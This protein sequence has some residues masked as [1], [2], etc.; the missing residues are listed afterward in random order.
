MP[1]SES[2]LRVRRTA[3]GRGCK[4][5]FVFYSHTGV[6]ASE[7]GKVR[8]LSPAELPE[9]WDPQ[10]DS[11]LTVWEMVHHLIRILEFRVSKM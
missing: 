6:L 8:L 11:R 1:E 3:G 4:S 2:S 7:G 5:R 9:D 10:A